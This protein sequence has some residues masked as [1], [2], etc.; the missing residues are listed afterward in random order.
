VAASYEHGTEGVFKRRGV[1]W[2]VKETVSMSS[3]LLQAAICNEN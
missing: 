3:N 2:P 1:P